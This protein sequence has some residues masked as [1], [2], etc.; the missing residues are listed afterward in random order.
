MRGQNQR[1]DSTQKLLPAWSLVEAGLA[2]RRE[3][4][5]CTP[6][7]IGS[8]LGVGGSSYRRGL[9]GEGSGSL[10]F[11]P[12]GSRTSEPLRSLSVQ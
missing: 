9:T 12:G 11:D 6:R 5:A 1:C 2:G 7:W 4:P 3:V 10:I 8:S